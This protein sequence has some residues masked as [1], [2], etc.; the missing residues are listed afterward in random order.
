M[1]HEVT[2]YENPPYMREEL[3]KEIIL[4]SVVNGNENN[5]S[6][7]RKDRVGGEIKYCYFTSATHNYS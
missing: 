6:K 7:H 3:I 4:L 1:T 2:Y 5:V